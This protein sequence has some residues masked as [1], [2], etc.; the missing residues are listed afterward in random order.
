MHLLLDA[1]LGEHDGILPVVQGSLAARLVHRVEPADLLGQP[2]GE[3]A[4]LGLQR[5]EAIPALVK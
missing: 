1:V 3:L 4:V 5:L 2:G